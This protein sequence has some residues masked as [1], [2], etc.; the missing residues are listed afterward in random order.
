MPYL[1]D[2]ARLEWARIEAYFAADC[3]PIDPGRLASVAP[4]HLH[5]LTLSLHPSVQL[6]RSAYPIF[7]IWDVNQD[8]HDTITNINFSQTECGLVFREG[9]TV[10]QRIIGRDRFQWLK[11]ISIGRTFGQAT[12]ATVAE[13]PEFDLQD[14]LHI[15][16]TSGV[17]TNVRFKRA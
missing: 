16:L 7:R 6:I 13:F 10:I 14:T 15:L 3:V 8:S 9:H 2:V 5:S 4:E 11:K 12:E 17:F 1:P